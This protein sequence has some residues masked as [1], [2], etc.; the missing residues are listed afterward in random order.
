MFCDA[1]YIF[2]YGSYI[3]RIII[4]AFK[5]VE[6]IFLIA[7][8]LKCLLVSYRFAICSELEGEETTTQFVTH[9]HP[10]HII[11]TKLNLVNC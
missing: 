2:L 5:K 4:D 10:N 3:R 6:N 1:R 8:L 7:E 11:F 9:C